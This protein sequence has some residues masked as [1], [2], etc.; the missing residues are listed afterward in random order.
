M[1][2]RRRF[3]KNVAFA[4]AGAAFVAPL[5][6]HSRPARRRITQSELDHAIQGHVLWLGN[7]D[8]GQRANFSR[9][10]LSGLDF[11]SQRKEQVVLRGA[12]FTEADLSGIQGN[13]INFHCASFQY[14]DLSWSE[15]KA[16]VFSGA[17]LCNVD[18]SAAVWGWPER[19]AP[20]RPGSVYAE[21]T[22]VFMHT[23]LAQTKFDRARVRGYFSDCS[24]CEASLVDAD[25]SQSDF[26][27]SYSDNSFAGAK[28]VRTKFHYAS[29]ASARFKRSVIEG[30]D[31]LSAELKPQIAQ[32]LSERHA[33]NVQKPFGV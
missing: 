15:L 29:I 9:C 32:L 11:G 3:I 4:L 26:A 2:E 24:L 31:F 8:K 23:Y 7:R 19:S 6:R 22:A 1:T 28:L 12:D 14:A 20:L 13:D 17:L 30:A 18:C 27:G 25:F 5:E 21:E 16:P 10:N 33:L